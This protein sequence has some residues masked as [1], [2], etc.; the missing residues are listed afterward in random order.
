M[1]SAINLCCVLCAI[2]YLLLSA[3]PGSASFEYV[4][5]HKE[6]RKLTEE[7]EDYVLVLW[8]SKTCKVWSCKNIW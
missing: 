7:E 5:D 4:D 8:T 6:M 1:E 2:L 3:A